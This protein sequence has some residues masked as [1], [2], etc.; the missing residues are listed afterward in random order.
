MAFFSIVL[1]VFLLK[2]KGN[3]ATASSIAG[4]LSDVAWDTE[5]AETLSVEWN[6]SY[7][8]KLPCFLNG[9]LYRV[10]PAIWNYPDKTESN[11]HWFNG[12][13]M[14][15]S[16]KFNSNPNNNSISISYHCK[17]L[18]TSIYNQYDPNSNFI[19]KYKSWNTDVTIRRINNDTLLTNTG[20]INSNS[21][22]AYNLNT[23]SAPYQYNDNIW[24]N[25]NDT[26]NAPSHSQYDPNTKELF[27]YFIN[28]GENANY[29]F[30]NIKPNT[31]QRILLEKH[32]F[33]INKLKIPLYQH[34]FGLT[35]NYIIICEQPQLLGA[36]GPGK[37]I[38]N[39]NNTWYVLNRTNGQLIKTF[40]S[41]TFSYFHFINTY[42]NQSK[43]IIDLIYDGTNGEI[44]YDSL[45]LNNMIYN[46]TNL[47]KT[48][49]EGHGE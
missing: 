21:F 2:C 4:G 27:H 6:I 19:P 39:M 40:I 1:F 9:T 20:E 8:N 29:V 23:I 22:S 32:L 14:L 33:P 36:N 16:F 49:C 24:Q 5:I 44:I 38:P 41:N 12:L 48:I 15:L 45:Y 11:P 34:S 46:Y 37:W 31:N 18:N 7:L 35:K 26:T 28:H 43:I 17:F 13:S 10:T 42:E 25:I 3:L 47:I 30:Y